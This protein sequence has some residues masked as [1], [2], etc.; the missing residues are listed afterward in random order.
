MR[1]IQLPQPLH[2][3]S[4]PANHEQGIEGNN[5]EED[6]KCGLDGPPPA[7]YEQGKEE[8]DGFRTGFDV[9]RHEGYAVLSYVEIF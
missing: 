7:D 8:G 4:F 6:I 9:W 5:Q 1:N 2:R 3:G